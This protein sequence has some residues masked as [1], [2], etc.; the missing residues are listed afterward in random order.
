MNA[1]ELGYNTMIKQA[2]DPVAEYAA[3]LPAN[4]ALSGVP[5]AGVVPHLSHAIGVL[6]GPVRPQ[7]RE[8][9]ADR[10]VAYSLIPGVAGHNVGRRQ[11]GS[12]GDSAAAG[13]HKGRVLSHAL[14]EYL[15]AG[16]LAG[17][18]VGGAAGYGV[19]D[20]LG[21]NRGLGAALGVA[22]G[23]LLPSLIGA[24]AAGLT[25]RRTSE[26]QVAHD[27]GN[28]AQNLIPGRD[29]YNLLKRLGSTRSWG[30]EEPK[31]ADTEKK[32]A[33]PINQAADKILRRSMAMRG[34]G[35]GATYGAA[36]GGGVG[37]LS[38][39]LAP[40][41]DE[42][43]K[44]RSRYEQMLYK[45]LLGATIGGAAMAGVGGSAGYQA[46]KSMEPTLKR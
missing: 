39:A 9:L 32:A 7:E 41:Y 3:S 21:G 38:G 43:G 14:G 8:A 34:A 19:A 18:G 42:E 26:E 20:A 46:A 24:I 45:G 35:A 23:G 17:A 10:D 16:S 4:I 29:V 12:Y 36:L 5:G 44:R 33:M 31:D 13:V 15:G 25:K 11:R 28:P 37:A 6:R 40:G 30:Q 1:Y 2:A 27:R 22:A